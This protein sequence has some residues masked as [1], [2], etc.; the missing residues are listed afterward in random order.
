MTALATG[1]TG[2]NYGDKGH[3][4]IVAN[5]G[6]TAVVLQ[7]ASSRL[8]D[9]AG[10]PLALTP[11]RIRQWGAWLAYFGRIGYNT[12]FMR[13]RDFYTVPAAWPHEF[14]A[15]ATM[16]GDYAAG[17]DYLANRQRGA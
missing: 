15:E 9:A 4:F 17:D 8:R 13:Q 10:D 1:V 6:K 12:R 11:E 7:R 16:L 14:D 5:A 2:E 3:A